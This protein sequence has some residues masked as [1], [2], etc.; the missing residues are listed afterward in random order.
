TSSSLSQT[1]TQVKQALFNQTVLL[2]PWVVQKP[3]LTDD[4]RSP[5]AEF[6]LLDAYEALYGGAA[7]GGKSSALLMAAARWLDFPAYNAIIFRKTLQDHKRPDGL[8]ARTHEWWQNTPA[9][10]NGQDYKWTFPSGA[11]LTLG[12]MD[13]DEDVYHHQG[14]AYNFIGWD[15]LTQFKQWQYEYLISRNRR[16]ENCYIPL[17]IRAATNPGGVGHAWVKQYF[18]IEGDKYGRVFIPAK[19]DDNPFL[20]RK[21]YE[22]SLSKMNPTLRAQLRNG[23]WEAQIGNM[24]NRAWFTIIEQ[25][26]APV[27]IKQVRYWDLAS[28]EAEKGKDPDWTS[29]ALV[30]TLNG[31]YFIFNIEHFQKTPKGTA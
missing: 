29:G 31:Q 5:Q 27:G 26:Q 4:G 23:S 3:A 12:Y 19:L 7:G 15:E 21:S 17:Q 2:N 24:F 13:N 6:L 8:I 14:A 25:T 10:W 22:F 9:R 18:L 30:G 28:T 1:K 20:D 11:T 16:L